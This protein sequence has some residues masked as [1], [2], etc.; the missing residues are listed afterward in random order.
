MVPSPTQ[1]NRD[2]FPSLFTQPPSP[3]ALELGPF[4]LHASGAE[5]KDGSDDEGDL[6]WEAS[7][8]DLLQVSAAPL[9]SPSPSLPPL[10]T[11]LLPP[12]PLLGTS[13]APTASPGFP[14]THEVDH[15]VTVASPPPVQVSGAETE[16]GW[17]LPVPTDVGSDSGHDSGH[18]RLS[19]AEARIAEAED[20]Q[21][22]DPLA[23]AEAAERE[24]LSGGPDPEDNSMSRRGDAVAEA[25]GALAP[26]TLPPTSCETG[27]AGL[28]RLMSTHE[29]LSL[30]VLGNLQGKPSSIAVGPGGIV[31]VGT[32]N[33]VIILSRPEITIPPPS[34]SPEHLGRDAQGNGGDA[35]VS[36]DAK[37]KSKMKTT[38]LG[39]PV[40]GATVSSLAFCAASCSRGAG[41]HPADTWLLAGHRDG[42]MVLWD[43]IRGA[44]VKEMR[45]VHQTPIVAV[46]L[47]SPMMAAAAAA[48]ARATA[49]G[50]GDGHVD[51]GGG[52]LASVS[53]SGMA[54]VE[55]LSASL[56]GTVSRHTLTS[57]GPLV[58]ARAS[59]LGERTAVHQFQPLPPPSAPSSGPPHRA[60]AAAAATGMPPDAPA[61]DIDASGVVAL[62][63]GG[64]IIVMCLHPEAGVLA[65]LPRPSAS[66]THPSQTTT[67]PCFAWAPRVLGADG[68]GGSLGTRAAVS[69]GD[70][71]QLLE[72]DL[73]AAVRPALSV[74]ARGPMPSTPPVRRTPVT[75]RVNHELKLEVQ[76]KP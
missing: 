64:A 67:L 44:V 59:C 28:V 48:A 50:G 19:G 65:K 58:R 13:R 49:H 68:T 32:T 12:P 10:P 37:K 72:L 16:A 56:A 26:F 69:W 42:S 20:E 62:L 15:T 52:R 3:D 31:A 25:L 73:A 2:A 6:D 53:L 8:R 39:I 74:A 14:G 27:A 46:A 47:V 45:G 30:A 21:D 35:S 60:A 22:D 7:I 57:I 38:T 76:P 70:R 4:E 66:Q 55:A 18:E 51:G 24:L 9:P 54:P 63:T 5:F 41:F 61:G 43:V 17:K 23:E 40:P 29:E 11:P 1:A 75:M 36:T 71:I 33:G 34:S